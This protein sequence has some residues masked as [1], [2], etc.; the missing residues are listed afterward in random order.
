M[1]KIKYQRLLL[2]SFLAISSLSPIKESS[3]CKWLSIVKKVVGNKSIMTVI[4]AAAV[5]EEL[6]PFERTSRKLDA[7]EREYTYSSEYRRR[8]LK[9]MEEREQEL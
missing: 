9:N 1:T 8:H 2:L 6:K 7:M 5:G 3:A 4:A